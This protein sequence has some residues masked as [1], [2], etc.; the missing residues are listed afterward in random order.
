MDKISIIV[1][2]YNLEK[3]IETTV[4]SIRSQTY[5]EIEILLVDDG[6]SDDSPQILDRLAGTDERIKVIH[7]A[8]GGVTSARLAGVAAAN[9]EWI[10]FADGDDYIEP[11]MYEHLLKNA[12]K[13]QADISHCGYQMVFPSRVDYYY[14]T[15]RFVRRDKEDGL[16]DLLEGSFVEPG[17]WN[18]LYRRGL[19]QSL[20]YADKMDLSIRNTEDLLMNYYLFKEASCSVYED[21]CPYHYILRPNSAATSGTNGHKLDD[22]LKVMKQIRADCTRDETLRQVMDRR[23]VANLISLSSMRLGDQAALIR[24]RRAAARKELRERLPLIWKGNYFRKQKIQAVWTACLPASYAWVH[25][26]YAKLSGIDKKYEI[27]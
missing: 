21:F 4:A 25:R 16:K 27:K 1:P 19:F 13:Y 6:S 26:G 22:P 24:P 18:K 3:Y 12:H 14:N 9:G 23:I 17:L 2:V 7:Q 8:N 11:D 20:L 10:G 15:G 5:R